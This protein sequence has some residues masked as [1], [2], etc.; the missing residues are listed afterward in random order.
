MSLLGFA[1]VCWLL[2]RDFVLA[3]LLLAAI[4]PTSYAHCWEQSVLIQYMN[5]YYFSAFFNRGNNGRRLVGRPVRNKKYYYITVEQRQRYALPSCPLGVTLVHAY[6]VY[7]GRGVGRC[8]VFRGKV[9]SSVGNYQSERNLVTKPKPIFFLFF[10]YDIIKNPFLPVRTFFLFAFCMTQ[11]RTTPNTINSDTTK[12]L[13]CFFLYG[14]IKNHSYLALFYTLNNVSP[15][16]LGL[17]IASSRAVRSY[18]IPGMYVP[19]PSDM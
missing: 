12:A 13:F 7:G 9:K 10:L 18:G 11:V 2:E 3:C 15:S 6:M 1:F 4:Y 5:L 14:T 19:T 8:Q 16:L 17:S